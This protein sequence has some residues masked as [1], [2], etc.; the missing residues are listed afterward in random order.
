MTSAKPQG[1]PIAEGLFTWASDGPR[2]LGSRCRACAA[3]TFPKQSA[4]PRCTGRDMEER[5][6]DPIGTLWTFTIQ[7][8]RP[9]PPYAG[10][11]DFEP[12][13]VGY[14]ELPDGVM[15]ESR[16]TENEREKLEIGS[17]MELVIVPFGRGDS[18]KELLTFAFASVAHQG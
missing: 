14:V 6:L 17:R 15:V 18:G 4:C 10:P 9:K 2:L 12:Y 3:T 11:E 13:G 7:G 5:L 1:T 8:F 16:L